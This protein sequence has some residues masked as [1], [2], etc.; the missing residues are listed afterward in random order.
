MADTINIFRTIHFAN[1]YA[2]IYSSFMAICSSTKQLSEIILTI[3]QVY[4]VGMGMVTFPHWCIP[5][6]YSSILSKH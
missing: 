5:Y 4:Q 2:V 1:Q 6:D 3:I